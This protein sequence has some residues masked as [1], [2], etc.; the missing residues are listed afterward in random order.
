MRQTVA[1][2]LRTL[3]KD[4]T[5]PASVTCTESTIETIEQVVKYV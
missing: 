5:I 4:F 1:C 3:K 2:Y